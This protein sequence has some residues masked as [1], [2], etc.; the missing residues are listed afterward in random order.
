MSPDRIEALLGEVT[1]MVKDAEGYD[2]GTVREWLDDEGF[3]WASGRIVYKLTE[4]RPDHHFL[5]RPFDDHYGS[6]DPCPRFIAYDERFI[7][8]PYGYDYASQLVKVARD[9][10]YYLEHESPFPG[11]RFEGGDDV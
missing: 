2:R 5:D 1:K 6:V 10:E 8:F 9:P 7:Y 3:D 4:V 11:V